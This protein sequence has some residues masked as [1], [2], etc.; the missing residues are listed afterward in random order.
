MIKSIHTGEL[1]TKTIYFQRVVLYMST[2]KTPREDEER[3]LNAL[4]RNP[5]FKNCILEM[6]DISEDPIR[7]Q[8]LKLGDDAEDA[9]IE[10]IQKTG[11]KL[12]EEWAQKRSEQ[13]A[14]EVS[15]KLKHRPHGKK[16]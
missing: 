10:V 1:L 4:R 9:V 2:S 6:L 14:E 11:R 7:D 13:V 5:E 8:K 15:Q 3:I 12:L 16:K